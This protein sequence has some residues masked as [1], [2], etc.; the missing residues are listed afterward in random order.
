MLPDRVWNLGPPTYE[1]DAL[2]IALRGRARK[3]KITRNNDTYY[4]PCTSLLNNF[5]F[6][7]MK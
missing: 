7:L 1:S 5:V 2:P 3:T 4:W 6:I